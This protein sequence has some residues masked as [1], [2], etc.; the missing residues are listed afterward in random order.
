[1]LCV[2]KLNN[3]DRNE[4]KINI[5]IIIFWRYGN[6]ICRLIFKGEN[7]VY[8]IGRIMNICKFLESVCFF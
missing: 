4:K 6:V 7:L 2:I 1:M 8:L 3:I 5:K